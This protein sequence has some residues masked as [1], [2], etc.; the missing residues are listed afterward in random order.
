MKIAI[1]PNAHGNEVFE[2]LVIDPHGN[3]VQ[4]P[5]QGEKPL[6]PGWRDATSEDLRVAR[7]AEED[8]TARE[9]KKVEEEKAKIQARAATSEGGP[10]VVGVEQKLDDRVVESDS[11]SRAVSASSAGYPDADRGP[12]ANPA[13]PAPTERTPEKPKK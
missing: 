2:R 9:R 5:W 10:I 8:R 4:I 12:H 13:V 7:D 1:G 6:K 3:L 11:S